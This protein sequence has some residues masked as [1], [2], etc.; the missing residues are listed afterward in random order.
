MNSAKLQFCFGL[1][2]LP[3]SIFKLPYLI[4]TRSQLYPELVLIY[5]HLKGGV[6]HFTTKEIFRT[7]F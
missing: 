1:Q 2:K 4:M 5:Q 6:I 3:S 7:T